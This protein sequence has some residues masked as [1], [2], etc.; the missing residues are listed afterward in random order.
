MNSDTH[1]LPFTDNSLGPREGPSL[2]SGQ[3]TITESCSRCE[4]DSG[5]FF[6]SADSIT[7]LEIL[8]LFNWHG[9]VVHFKPTYQNVP[10]RVLHSGRSR[11]SSFLRSGVDM[12]LWHDLCPSTLHVTIEI[13]RLFVDQCTLVAVRVTA[14]LAFTY[15]DTPRASLCSSAYRIAPVL[16]SEYDLLSAIWTTQIFPP[17]S[18]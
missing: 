7:K 14:T 17:A 12:V 11:T 6:S 4:R 10:T 16:S 9:S 5:H 13:L 8:P 3:A 18:P 1:L 15:A 2:A